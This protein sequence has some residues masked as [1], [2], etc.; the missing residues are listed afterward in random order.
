MGLIIDGLIGPVLETIG[1]ITIDE[2]GE[3]KKTEKPQGNYQKKERTDKESLPTRISKWFK[4]LAHEHTVTHEVNKFLKEAKE[5]QVEKDLKE[6]ERNLATKKNVLNKLGRT[7]KLKLRKISKMEAKALAGSDTY[8]VWYGD[9]FPYDDE[10]KEKVILKIR[11][12][13]S[14]GQSKINTLS[15]AKAILDYS[16]EVRDDDSTELSKSYPFLID[17]PFTELSG[18]NLEMSSRNIHSFSKQIILMI[19]EESL[20]GVEG[21]ILPYVCN[22]YRLA[23]SDGESNSSLQED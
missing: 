4:G 18:G 10:I 19:S 23:K 13:N 12:S 20:S 15:F 6:A 1:V 21:N 7:R 8:K 11:E 17:S 22:S 14:T 2:N 16:S 9:D 3:W 5:N